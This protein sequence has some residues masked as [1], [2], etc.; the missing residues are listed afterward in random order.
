MSGFQAKVCKV[1]AAGGM[2]AG[3]LGLTGCNGF[4]IDGHTSVVLTSSAVSAALSTS[5]TLTAKISASQA[6]GTVEFYDGSTELGTATVSSGK[7]TYTT[8][9]L[10]QGTH[11]L[12]AEYQ[13]DS[14]YQDSTS[15]ALT[16]VISGTL[17]STTTTVAAS[18]SS[19]TA[20]TSVMF[21]ATVSSSA[22][23]GTVNFYDASGSTVTL[24]GSSTLNTGVATYSTTT[25]ATGTHT[26]Y[27]TYV[28]DSTYAT[29]TSST[30]S[31]GVT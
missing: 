2:L 29:S 30:I 10:T 15:D 3:A 1:L 25:L 4:F 27:A 8:S 7:A 31:V 11:S 12:T 17:T 19:V 26:I 16:V 18:A 13:G 14:T 28:G 23:T 21:T 5:I 20:G 9:A 22:A 6:T 24:I